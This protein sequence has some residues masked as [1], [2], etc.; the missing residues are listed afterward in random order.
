MRCPACEATLDRVENTSGLAALCA[1]CGGVWVDWACWRAIEM[2]VLDHAIE[3]ASFAGIALVKQKE[4]AAFRTAALRAE[5]ERAC[6]VCG[7]RLATMSAPNSQVMIDSCITHGV[8]FD[9]GEM[10]AQVQQV[11]IGA[12]M[13]TARPDAL[14][15][16]APGG[17]VEIVQSLLGFRR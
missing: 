9:V 2:N 16:L 4:A 6:V 17:L 13:R 8:W 7:Q 5:S 14:P 11:R 10:W 12:A 1:G 15:P 3:E